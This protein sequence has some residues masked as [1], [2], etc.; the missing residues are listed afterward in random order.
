MVKI[1]RP[2]T[3]TWTFTKESFLEMFDT[4]NKIYHISKFGSVF[5]NI[6]HSLRLGQ[7]GRN[8]KG[9]QFLHMEFFIFASRTIA[10]ISVNFKNAN[11]EINLENVTSKSETFYL[12]YKS[13]TQEMYVDGICEV[14]I[15]GLFEIEKD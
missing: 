2:I 12:P 11:M 9:K 7:G 15:S 10:N 4:N 13:L 1:Y 3:E 6:Y 5:P 14:E 8:H